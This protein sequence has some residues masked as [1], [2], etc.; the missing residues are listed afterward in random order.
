MYMMSAATHPGVRGGS[1]TGTAVIVISSGLSNVPKLEALRLKAARP[2]GPTALTA[3]I[4]RSPR[5]SRGG[6]AA[7]RTRGLAYGLV[8][9]TLTLPVGQRAGYRLA[10]SGLSR[11]RPATLCA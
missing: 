9:V 4:P 2:P 1:A 7:G 3:I 11:N 10:L 8:S 5:S 6:S